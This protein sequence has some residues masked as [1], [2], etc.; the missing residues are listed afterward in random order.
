MLQYNI[1]SKATFADL[2]D[3]DQFIISAELTPPRHYDLTDFM[4]KAEIV[5]EYVHVLQIND[6]LLSHARLTNLVVGQQC[7]LAGMETVMQFTLRH[8][9][10]IA[11]QGDLLGYAALGLR[12]I[13][14]LG[15][16]PCSLGNDPKAKDASDIGSVEAIR[17]ISEMTREG[18]LFNGDIISPPP[19]F[20]I[21]VIDF[22]CTPDRMEKSFDRLEKK[23]E[24]GA[25]FVQVQ[26]VFETAPMHRWM[27]EV[28][29]RKLHLK[30]RFIGAVFPFT[31]LERLHV[32][33]EIPGLEIPESLLQR[34]Q[35]K[36]NESESLAVTLELIAAIRQ[37][38]G[39]S[40]IHIRSIGVEDWVP[41]IIEASGLGGDVIY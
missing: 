2:L 31:G 8:K 26:A 37:M 32:L 25:D 1:G 28:V 10:R 33:G 29:R 15:G 6:H 4:R 18:K 16:Y 36:N 22:P 14:V 12:N 40:G 41:R 39:I 20:K 38:E 34:I 19:V 17:K 27:E 21:G 23:I 3:S 5:N 11:L 24:A 35:Q 7:K 13:I 30:V 9:N